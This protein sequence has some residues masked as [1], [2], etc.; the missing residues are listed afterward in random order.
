MY[1][2]RTMK[3]SH[4]VTFKRLLFFIDKKYHLQDITSPKYKKIF[5]LISLFKKKI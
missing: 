3:N 5:H 4:I 1:P 2:L